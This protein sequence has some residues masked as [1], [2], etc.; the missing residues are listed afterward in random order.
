MKLIYLTLIGLASSIHI[1]HD[2]YPANEEFVRFVNE[3]DESFNENL[4][5][6]IRVDEIGDRRHLVELVGED[7]GDHP[8]PAQKRRPQDD[9][10]RE[11]PEHR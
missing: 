2:R 9:E 3:D 1:D 7:P 4:S 6:E 5:K 11:H 8:Q 10:Q